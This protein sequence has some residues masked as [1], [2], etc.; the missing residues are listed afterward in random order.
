MKRLGLPFV[1]LSALF[2]SLPVSHANSSAEQTHPAVVSVD[3]KESG[4]NRFDFSVTILSPYD[5]PERYADA[6]RVMDENG[7][8]LGVRQ[9]LH[10]HANEQPFT[11]GLY[12]IIIPLGID[13]VV[14]QGR[15]QLNGWGGET[16][17]VDLPGRP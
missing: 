9:L 2:S 13:R 11:R 4:A 1:L 16:Q 14:I 17:T 7:D 12:G 10:H 15:D 6:F 3:I 8:V 5:A